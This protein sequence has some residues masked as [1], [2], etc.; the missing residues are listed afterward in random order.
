MGSREGFIKEVT[1]EMDLN[2]WEGWAR[3]RGI[4]NKCACGDEDFR[5][6]CPRK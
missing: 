3:R 2:R 6:I 1:L 4:Y 5:K